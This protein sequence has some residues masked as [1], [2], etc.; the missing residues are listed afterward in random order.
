MNHKSVTF[1]WSVPAFRK[2]TVESLQL[3]YTLHVFH[4]ADVQYDVVFRKRNI[5]MM[6][7]GMFYGSAMSTFNHQVFA[8]PKFFNLNWGRAMENHFWT[9]IWST[10]KKIGS[11]FSPESN[12]PHLSKTSSNFSHCPAPS[13][14]CVSS[15]KSSSLSKLVS[16]WTSGVTYVFFCEPKEFAKPIFPFYVS[17]VAE[18][19]KNFEWYM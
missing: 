2:Y 1:N 18:R 7:N 15:S 19:S 13:S 5:A 11:C 6:K 8:F 12:Y 3:P 10:A 17:S 4:L 9:Q 16:T 14:T